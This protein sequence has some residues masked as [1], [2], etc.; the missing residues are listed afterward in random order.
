MVERQGDV[1]Y[2][3]EWTSLGEYLDWLQRRGVSTNV[4][5]FVGATTV[6]IHELGYANRKA[7][8][9]ELER[10][11][12]TLLASL[13]QVAPGAARVVLADIHDPGGAARV[14]IELEPE[15][16]AADNAARYLKRAS[17]LYRRRQVVPARLDDCRARLEEVRGLAR[18]LRQGGAD[19]LERVEAWLATQDSEGPVRA[20]PTPAP[21]DSA[22][23]R[24]YRTSTGWSVWAGRSNRENDV[25]THRLAAQNDYWFHAHG[26][27]GAHV[28]LR[29]EGRV[30]EPSAATLAEAAAVAAYWS[31][32]KTAR[33]VPVIYA[34]VRHVSRPRGAPAGQAAVRR[35]KTLMVQPRLLAAEDSVV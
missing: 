10:K 22:H 34:L 19:D 13:A 11:G 21:R 6:R 2:D 31:K 17:K 29:R 14:E 24:R 25:L 3:V 7:T 27:T 9:E 15:R 26:Y 18:D 1:R 4:A 32:G 33:R 35:E 20:G 16:T 12:T 23:P 5:S 30:E 28:I 8:A